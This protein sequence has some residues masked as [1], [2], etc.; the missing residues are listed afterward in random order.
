M[1][2]NPPEYIKTRNGYRRVSNLYT[3]VVPRRFYVKKSGRY[4]PLTLTGDI[5]RKDRTRLSAHILRTIDSMA[6]SPGTYDRMMRRLHREGYR[7][8]PRIRTS[9]RERDP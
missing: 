3:Q 4:Y 2:R 8:P 6:G 5:K 1:P 7:Q 9:Q